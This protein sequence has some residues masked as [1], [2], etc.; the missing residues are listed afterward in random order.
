MSA[1]DDFLKAARTPT[2]IAEQEHHERTERATRVREKMHRAR[3]EVMDAMKIVGERLTTG[4][5]AK[6]SMDSMGQFTIEA[7]GRKLQTREEEGRAVLS[8]LDNGQMVVSFAVDG[9]T[10]VL[11][12]SNG[13]VPGW[14][15]SK[16]KDAR[17]ALNDVEDLVFSVVQHWCMHNGVLG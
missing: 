12:V 14:S 1:K 2:E 5:R 6:V 13:R 9:T 16:N 11:R 17:R 4:A 15:E 3:R 10:E 8:F 7:M